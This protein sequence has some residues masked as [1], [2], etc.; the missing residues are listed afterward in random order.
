MKN[1]ENKCFPQGFLWGVSTASYQIEGGI[2]NDWSEWEKSGE[3]IRQITHEGKNPEN[4]ICGLACDSYNRYEEDAEI[5]KSLNCNAYR[6]SIEWARIEPREGEF[7]MVEIEH[8]RNVLLLLREKGITPFVTIWHWTNPV[9]LAEMGGW[10]NKNLV[11]YYKRYVEKLVKELGD[12][13]NFWVT[14]NEPLMH[15]GHG[16]LTGKFPP[17]RKMDLI[18]AYRVFNNLV[19]A[20]ITGEKAIHSRNPKAQVSIAMTTGFIEPANKYNPIEWIIAKIAHYFRN[21]FFIDKIKGSYDY[22]GVNYYHHDRI[23]WYPPFRKNLNE[24]TTD[25]GW[26]IYPEGIYHVLKKYQKFGKP[27]Y[28]LENGIA[29]EK[30]LQRADFIRDHL[31]FIHKAINEGADIRG[32]FHWSLLDNFEW[33]EGYTMKFGLCEVNRKTFE[34]KPRGSA[35]VYSKICK[36]NSL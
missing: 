33:A 18:G 1:N 20:H 2:T 5:I 16:Y 27:L 3:R 25:F 15:I 11:S 31:R 29:D 9:W 12:L 34:R 7:D 36:N 28:I 17:N 10:K 26:E 19:K 8:Y 4:Y 14:L 22:L 21:E 13:V 23:V 35:D 32:Y 6:F 24:K 30:D